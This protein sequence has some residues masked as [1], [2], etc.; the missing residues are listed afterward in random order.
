MQL[1]GEAMSARL[2]EIQIQRPGRRKPYA[3]PT[4]V[5]RDRLARITAERVSG[6]VT[7]TAP[8]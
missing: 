6:I 4:L 2:E 1:W 3:S 5:R 8:R 7:D